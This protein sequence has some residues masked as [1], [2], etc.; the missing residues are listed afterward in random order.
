MI[1]T[2]L[3]DLA[4]GEGLT[5]DLDY[6]PKLVSW[7]ISLDP[8]GRCLG[9]ISTAIPQGPKGKPVAK[10]MQIPRRAGRTSGDL[11]DFLVDK[12][13]YVLGIV[14]DTD[15]SER[16]MKRLEP[17][18]LLFLE[19]IEKA[20]TATSHAGIGAVAAFLRS[21][22]ERGGIVAKLQQQGYASNNL[23][24]FEVQGRLVHQDPQVRSYFST[25]R[26]GSGERSSQC[27]MCGEFRPLVDKHPSVQIRGGSS[28]GI[29]LVSFNSGAFESF[30]WERNE[31]APICR[32]CAE[33]YT[34]GL[35]RL[36]SNR[37]PDPRHPGAALP[38]RCVGLTSDTIAVFWAD[39]ES[40]GLDWFADIFEKPDPQAIKSLFES[41]HKGRDAPKLSAR[42]YCLLLSGGQGRA[43][44]RGMHTGVLGDVE[45]NVREYFSVIAPLSENPLPLFFLL[46]SLAVQ[47]KADNLPPS[48]A[49]EVFLAILFGFKY[50]HSLLSSAV[51]RNR[52][53][54]GVSRE[55]TA[56]LQLYFQRNLKRQELTMGLNRESPDTGYRL[57]RLLAVL[58]R[59]QGQANN[60]LNK[61]IVDRYY[62]A[63]STR[64]VTVFPSLI[65]L[66][67]HHA[68]KARNPGFF[69][70]EIG[71]VLDAVQS[72]PSHLS[73]EEQGLFALGYYHQRQ[74]YFKKREAAPSGGTAA[75]EEG[76]L[77][78]E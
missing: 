42:F 32:N 58:E 67:Q 36:V 19:E 60:S 9:L 27:L 8:E 78:N 13:E 75:P 23:I 64:P 76:D 63:A 77:N 25:R 43:I 65:H 21:D 29:A 49:G 59:L 17:R 18:R 55:R 28:S 70:K 41:S 50:P 74:E 20:A 35:R 11:A 62:G 45:D 1:L 16:R 56:I 51:Q 24:C 37:Y 40:E 5:E 7:V 61:T 31:N 14:P 26:A 39:V 47:G 48:L 69:Q 66:A 44:I 12:P 73:L 71:E 30:G 54:Q 22:S 46:R 72:F 2:S 6:E 3:K 10:T 57:G 4:Q 52:A 15:L 38:R 53:E 68:G 34:T 33:G